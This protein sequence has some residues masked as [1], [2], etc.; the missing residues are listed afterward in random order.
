MNEPLYN[1]AL[2]QQK[3]L[4][5]ESNNWNYPP[6]ERFIK[7]CYFASSASKSFSEAIKR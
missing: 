4:I 1:P 7:S 6:R 3:I 2:K 5:K